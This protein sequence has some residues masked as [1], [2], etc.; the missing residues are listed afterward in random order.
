MRRDQAEGLRRLLDHN[1]LR[2]V[3]ISAGAGGSGK[4]AAIINLAGALAELG[5]DV[6]ILDENP[7]AQGVT[8]ALGLKARFDLEDVIRRER[9]LDEVIVR[10]PAGILILPLARG[11]RSLSRLPAQEQQR[12]VERCG[13]LGFP[14]DTLLVDAAPGSA[15]ALLWPGTAAQEVIVL[16]GGSAAAI[17]AAYALIKRLSSEFGRREFHVLIGNVASEREARIIFA[18]MAG[19]ARRYLQVA[20]DFMGH[21]PP[22]DKL[23]HA[24]RLRLPVVAAFPAAVAAGSFRCLAQAVSGWPQAEEDGSGFD[25]FMRRLIHSSRA[26]TAAAQTSF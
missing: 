4:T 6:L 11:A 20:L 12:L 22:D 24:A 25:D 14:V 17:T 19:T 15:S 26:R 3:A 7:A 21:I 9:D 23:Q 16:E 13:R 8:A 2:V 10:G 5:S 18:N 1:R